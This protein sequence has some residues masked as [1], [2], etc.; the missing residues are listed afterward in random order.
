MIDCGLIVN[1][2]A[3]KHQIE[4]SVVLGTSSALRE[5]VKFANGKVLNPSFKEYAPITMREAPPVRVGFV[6]D[7]TQPMTGVGEPGVAPIT[8]AIANA[9]YDLTG[10]R[11]YDTPF[12]ADRVLAELQKATGGT[13]IAATPAMGTPA[14]TPIA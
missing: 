10:I 8:G 14:A 9:L 7:K 2:E 5:I 1:P 11:L 13:P 6:E 12:T 3:V 4:G